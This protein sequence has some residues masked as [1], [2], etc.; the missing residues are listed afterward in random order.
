MKINIILNS[1][2]ANWILEKFAV[3]TS[4]ELIK[5][6]HDVRINPEPIQ[7]FDVNHYLSY[8]FVLNPPAKSTVLVTHIDDKSK[9]HF[10]KN[11]AKNENINSFIC[12]SEYTRNFLIS[13][14]IPMYRVASVLPG[15]DSIP[16]IRAIRIGLSS[17]I[18]N[19]GRKNESWLQ[20]LSEELPLGGFEFHIFGSGWEKTCEKLI[21][22]GADVIY[23]KATTDFTGDHRAILDSLSFVD[24]W[25]YLGFDE[26]SMGCLDA[27][28]AGVPLIT[29]P[30][31]FHLD[32]PGGIAHPVSSY[33]ELKSTT[34]QLRPKWLGRQEFQEQYS[35]ERYARE[36]LAIWEKE[37]HYSKTAVYKS[38]GTDFEDPDIKSPLVRMTF[39]RY[40]SSFGRLKLIIWIRK[41][42]KRERKL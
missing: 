10:V 24:F 31:G 23:T 7:E 11:L 1:Q 5:L 28:L 40:V 2:N 29:T 20:R 16:Q 14:G 18:Y 25:M 42:F 21:Q 39:R 8:N 22:A 38:S 4:F 17:Y 30:Q 3:K 27:A 34:T 6:G 26:G 32:L 15:V 12:L 13:E 19:D 33:E 37:Y 41:H 36:C 9:L 35:W